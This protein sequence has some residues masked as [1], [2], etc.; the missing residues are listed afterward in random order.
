MAEWLKGEKMRIST[1][2]SLLAMLLLSGCISS[3]KVM[4]TAGDDAVVILKKIHSYNAELITVSDSAIFYEHQ[5]KIHYTTYADLKLVLIK[6]YSPNLYPIIGFF[7]IPDLIAGRAFISDDEASLR[8]IG[9]MALFHAGLTTAILIIQSDKDTFSPATSLKEREQLKLYCRY[10]QGLTD[11]QWK[12]LLR[13]DG[14]EGF[15]RL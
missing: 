3:V 15:L 5:G 1:L 14:Q 10:P 8:Q 2:I 9:M 13:I 4:K 12:E 11:E 6:G 7:I